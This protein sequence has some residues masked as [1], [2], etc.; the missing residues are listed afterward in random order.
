MALWKIK[1]AI[2]DPAVLK[3][4]KDEYEQVVYGGRKALSEL[5]MNPT[6]PADLLPKPEKD[7]VIYKG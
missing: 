2:P 4:N 1:E 7:T 5:Y 3:Q 6:P